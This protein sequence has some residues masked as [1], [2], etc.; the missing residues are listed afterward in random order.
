VAPTLL[1]LAGYDELSLHM[2]GRSIIPLL[3][4]PSDPTVLPSTRRHIQRHA[5]AS[6]ALIDSQKQQLPQGKIHRV[7]PK[8]AS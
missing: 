5:A 4:D 7:D 8:L 2:D 1:G 6:V 3:V